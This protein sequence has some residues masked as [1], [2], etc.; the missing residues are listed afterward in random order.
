MT[1]SANPANPPPVSRAA[2]LIAVLLTSA[3]LCL[4]ASGALYLV[5]HARVGA[6][7][8]ASRPATPSA[9]VSS[10][11]ELNVDLLRFTPSPPN[12]TPLYLPKPT[13]LRRGLPTPPEY[14]A[15]APPPDA[16]PAT[17]PADSAPIENPKSKVENP[18]PSPLPPGVIPWT[19]AGQY[20]GKIVTIQG[21]IVETFTA[22]PG[23]PGPGTP[24]KPGTPGPR[25]PEKPGTPG[26]TG[27]ATPLSG[28]GCVLNF[29]TERKG[30][31][32][33]L[34]QP[35]V[36]PS[37]PH[38]PAKYFLQR[39]VRVTGKV[40]QRGVRTQIRVYEASQIRVVE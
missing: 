7:P 34:L 13:A 1:S 39:T 25:T 24:E 4:V 15:T 29:T 19:Q 22:P 10:T 30:T 16:T 37:L 26:T 38:N 6:E 23:I 32:Y 28:G 40:F 9:N 2:N 3:V 31:F 36:M 5:Q 20:L 21:T 27:N 12:P 17:A 8:P 18:R 11:V 35:E 14:A 33:I